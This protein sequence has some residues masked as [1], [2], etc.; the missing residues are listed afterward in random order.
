MPLLIGRAGSLAAVAA[1]TDGTQEL[2]LVTQRDA[3]V[4]TPA[5]SD[6]HRVGVRARL[7]QVTRLAGGTTKILV[8]A[9]SRVRVQ[10]YTASRGGT[11]LEARVTPWPL[12]LKAAPAAAPDGD[13]ATLRHALSL[14]DEYANLHRRGAPAAPHRSAAASP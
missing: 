14:F 7:Q 12:A 5:S 2:L 9:V 8:E 13:S 1:A 3:D 10:R 4:Q 6:L 11:L